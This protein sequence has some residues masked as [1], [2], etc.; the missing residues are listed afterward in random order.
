MILFNF[1]FSAI[2]ADTNI[3]LYMIPNQAIIY[4]PEPNFPQL[5]R[6]HFHV[7]CLAFSSSVQRRKAQQM[8]DCS[9]EYQHALWS[10]TSVTAQKKKDFFFFPKHADYTTSPL[11]QMFPRQFIISQSSVVACSMRTRCSAAV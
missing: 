10:H 6:H 2:I 11:K 4:S 3:K 9:F 8:V 7:V 5:L 1:C